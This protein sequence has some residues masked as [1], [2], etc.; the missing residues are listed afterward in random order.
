[1]LQGS[2]T[3]AAVWGRKEELEKISEI[4]M[5]PIRRQLPESK[6]RN[7][8]RLRDAVGDL[9]DLTDE[10]RAA[11]LERLAEIEKDDAR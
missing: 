5:A 1:M 7:Y 9:Q 3:A 8:E 11:A 4:V 6:Q 10:A 2:Y